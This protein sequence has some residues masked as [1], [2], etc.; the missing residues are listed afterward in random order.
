MSIHASSKDI[1]LAHVL[2]ITDGTKNNINNQFRVAASILAMTFNG[3][4]VSGT[5]DVVRENQR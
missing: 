2:W 1:T 3:L 4:I 5:T